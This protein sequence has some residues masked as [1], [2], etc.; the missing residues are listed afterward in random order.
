MASTNTTASILGG[1]AITNQSPVATQRRLVVVNAARAVEGE[2]MVSYDNDK[3]GSNGRRNLMFAAVRALGLGLL[4][5][6]G[7]VKWGCNVLI[8]YDPLCTNCS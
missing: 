6:I 5:L 1:T 2:K 3:E 8:S 7:N 4:L